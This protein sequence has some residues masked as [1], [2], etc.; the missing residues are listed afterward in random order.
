LALA[1]GFLAVEE[2]QEVSAEN[3]EK[4]STLVQQAVREAQGA[5]SLDPNISTYWM[6]LGSVYRSLVGLVEGTLDWSVQSYQQAL[7]IDPVN[8]GIYMELGSMMY[9]AKAYDL[10][11]RYFEKAVINKQNF[12]NAWYNWAFAA[13]Q[14]NKLQDAVTRLNQAVAL[15][16]SDSEDYTKASDELASWQ[17]ELDE[18][19]AK[20]NEQVKQQQTQT[21]DTNQ[22]QIVAEPLTTPELLPEMGEEELVNVSEEEL[23]PP[24]E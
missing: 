4:A 18:A 14:Q 23:A 21:M 17:K 8:S 7:V 1:Q 19:V 10:A 3:K 5:V 2:G 22:Q 6:N 24:A 9:G 16:P 11:E 15:V 13:K 12:A 20:Y